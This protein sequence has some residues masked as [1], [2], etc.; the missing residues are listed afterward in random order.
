[1]WLREREECIKGKRVK[2]DKKEEAVLG[3]RG[4]ESSSYLYPLYPSDRHLNG[5]CSPGYVLGWIA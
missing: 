3:K 2:S 4:I 1:M 5:N